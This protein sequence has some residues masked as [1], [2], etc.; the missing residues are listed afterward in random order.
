LR[1]PVQLLSDCNCFSSLVFDGSLTTFDADN[2]QNR[3]VTSYI[4]YDAGL[5][6]KMGAGFSSG[7]THTA[8]FLNVE[9]G[10]SLLGVRFN[11]SVAQQKSG[12]KRELP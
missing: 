1:R 6:L 9:I 12:G 2:A 7:H 5:H 11:L 8:R 3:T 10:K 4:S